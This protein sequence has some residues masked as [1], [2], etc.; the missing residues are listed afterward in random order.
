MFQKYLSLWC[1]HY[2]LD[3]PALLGQNDKG[4]K[5]FWKYLVDMLFLNILSAVGSVSFFC[6]VEVLGECGFS[7]TTK[8]R[9]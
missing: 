9:A 2:F 6:E 7:L 3:N 8:K 1:K 4:R 5:A